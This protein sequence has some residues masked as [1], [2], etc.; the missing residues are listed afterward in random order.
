MVNLK[1]ICK[2]H[3]WD[4]KSEINATQQITTLLSKTPLKTLSSSFKV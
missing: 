4:K 2:S 3:R 1:V